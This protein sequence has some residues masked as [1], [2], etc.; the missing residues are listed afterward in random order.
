[1]SATANACSRSGR[2]A[3]S[4]AAAISL[5]TTTEATVQLWPSTVSGAPTR[6][7]SGGG[8]GVASGASKAMT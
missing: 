2:F 4:P 8:T 7:C 6:S 3:S 5:A 1:M